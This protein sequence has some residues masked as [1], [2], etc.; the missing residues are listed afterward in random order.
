MKNK[1]GILEGAIGTSVFSLLLARSLSSIS[2][3]S[4]QMPYLPFPTVRGYV[5]SGFWYFLSWISNRQNNFEAANFSAIQLASQIVV[6]E[7]FQAANN[8]STFAA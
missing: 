2:P 3:C 8:C 1:L 6:V 5:T 7:K 4:L